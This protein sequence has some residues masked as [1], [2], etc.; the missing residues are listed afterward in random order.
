M[1]PFARALI[2][3]TALLKLPLISLGIFLATFAI[4]AFRAWRMDRTLV[5]DL[6]QLPLHSEGKD[7]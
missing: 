7:P 2:E 1:G 5:H 3:G 6:E 4:V